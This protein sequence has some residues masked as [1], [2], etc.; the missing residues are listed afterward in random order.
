[1]VS[2]KMTLPLR[3]R[4]SYGMDGPLGLGQVIFVN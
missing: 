2:L 4:R 1:M 3:A